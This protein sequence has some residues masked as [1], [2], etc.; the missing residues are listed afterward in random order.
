MG[1]SFQLHLGGIISYT[2]SQPLNERTANG[3]LGRIA[4]SIIAC[5]DNLAVGWPTYSLTHFLWSVDYECN[6]PKRE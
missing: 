2:C 4:F 3:N 1:Y 6:L 5:P